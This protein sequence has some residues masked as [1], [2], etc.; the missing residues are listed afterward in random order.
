M[1]LLQ[2]FLKASLLQCPPLLASDSDRQDFTPNRRLFSNVLSVACQHTT[3]CGG[4]RFF[5]GRQN[6]RNPRR[7][8]GALSGWVLSVTNRRGFLK[9]KHGNQQ[10][11][12]KRSTD[13]AS[14]E[15]PLFIRRQGSRNRATVFRAFYSGCNA[16]FVD[17]T[18]LSAPR[19]KRQRA[20]GIVNHSYHHRE[21]A[22]NDP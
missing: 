9:Q 20:T 13:A 15:L 1:Q 12:T 21:D 16:R 11:V 7:I 4:S 5:T 17:G 2:L 6:P 22:E 8:E 3:N 18:V 19:S 10:C 14:V